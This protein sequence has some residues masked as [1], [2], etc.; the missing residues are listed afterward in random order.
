MNAA[1][2]LVSAASLAAWLYLLCGRGHFWRSVDR[3][4]ALIPSQGRVLMDGW[5]S[6][7]AVV[8]ARDEAGLIATSVGSLLQQDYP[9]RFD[10]VLVDDRSTDGTAAVASETAVRMGAAERL[11]II[12]GADPPP[13]W[14]GKLWAMEQGFAYLEAQSEPPDFVL[15]SDADIAYDASVVRQLVEG[16]C[17]RQTVLTSLMV[18]LRCESFAERMIIPAFIFFFQKL[19]P[20]AWVNNP[21]YRTAAAAGGCMLVHCDALR[22]AG[23]FRAIRGALIDDCALGAL[24]KGQGPIWLSLTENAD[25]LRAAPTL[26]DMRRMVARSAY[27][28]LRYSPLALFGAV[29]AMAVVYIAPP[30]L[31]VLAGGMARGF[32]L[33][34]WGLM[35]WAFVPTLRFYKVN[36]V[37]ALALPVI[38]SMY[39]LFTLDSALQHWR[40]RGGAWKGRFQA[41]ASRGM[42]ER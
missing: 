30:L 13:S 27:A 5:P 16:A 20:F 26:G 12:Q 37:R 4:D 29:L 32:G 22:R 34:A 25:S 41:A 9:A 39:I 14:T 23:G 1:A 42:T 7:V 15:F 17:A 21:T 18:K 33:A 28:Q 31:A 2:I 19:Y 11:T 35:T 10:V 6:V 3:D 38:A 36:P 8:P 40:G 24:L